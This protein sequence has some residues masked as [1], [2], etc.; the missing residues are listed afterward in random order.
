MEMNFGYLIFIAMITVSCIS[1][2]FFSFSFRLIISLYR[3]LFIVVF[4]SAD[5]N[6]GDAYMSMKTRKFDLLFDGNNHE[7]ASIET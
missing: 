4:C 7:Y 5:L 3:T 2:T 1:S 6:G